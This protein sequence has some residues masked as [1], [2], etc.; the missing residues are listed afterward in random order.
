MAN[1]IP[2]EI[3]SRARKNT[4]FIRSS[5]VKKASPNPNEMPTSSLADFIVALDHV[6]GIAN[7]NALKTNALDTLRTRLVYEGTRLDLADQDKAAWWLMSSGD[8]SAIKAVIATLGRPGWNDDSAR[9]MVGVAMRQERGHWDTTT[10]NAWGTI[11][12]RKFAGLYPASA[13]MGTTNL[14]FGNQ[15]ISKAWPLAADRRA[16]HLPLARSGPLMMTQTGGS[17]PWATVQV[18]AAVPLK[19]PLFAGY[20]MTRKVEAVSQRVAGR[21][22]RGDVLKVTITV[23]ASA[24]RNWVV[25][26]DP[27]PA[28]ATIIGDMANQSQLLQSGTSDGETSYVE[29][30]RD[31][32]R[33]YFGWMS[34]GSHTVSY[35][36]RLNGAG[37]FSLP[38][39]RV[40]AMYSPSINAQVPNAPVTIVMK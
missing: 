7:A 2:S 12:A 26:S 32:W 31:A 4:W 6:P 14:A 17:G 38:A 13:I 33:G 27:I 35:T 3:A 30:A 34:A 9:M 20:K 29:R 11:A 40:E 24:E 28:G 23:D 10:A 25:I 16:A 22:T 39:T 37:T 21:Y 15:N 1:G 5:V 18:S 36:M 19:Q 8:E